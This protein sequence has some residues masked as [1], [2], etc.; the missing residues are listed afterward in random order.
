MALPRLII[1]CP[2]ILSLLSI[3]DIIYAVS[4]SA[5]YVFRYILDEI[6][7]GSI[8]AAVCRSMFD[9]ESYIYVVRWVDD[10]ES[11]SYRFGNALTYDVR[12]MDK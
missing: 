4:S 9:G 6:K 10:E 2:A 11:G 7:Q 3:D 1:I 12:H 8:F 5:Y